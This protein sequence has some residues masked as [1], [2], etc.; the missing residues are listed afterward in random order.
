MTVQKEN[1]NN[2]P[3]PKSSNNRQH[4]SRSTEVQPW[5]EGKGKNTAERQVMNRVNR[6]SSCETF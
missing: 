5:R 1:P 3:W 4:S 2:F 6:V